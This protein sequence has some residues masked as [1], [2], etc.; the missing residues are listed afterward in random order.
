MTGQ[1]IQTRVLS[2]LGVICVITKNK[3]NNILLKLKPIT[4]QYSI[5]NEDCLFP[6][7]QQSVRIKSQ[8]SVWQYFGHSSF[9]PI[10]TIVF[11]ASAGTLTGI[12]SKLI[13]LHFHIFFTAIYRL[14]IGT[15][16]QITD[17]SEGKL[18]FSIETR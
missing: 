16:A 13:K 6:F 1:V 14:N 8:R 12:F 11:S 10:L 17:N 5:L 18:Y 3:G 9:Q 4:M 7:I 2:R 15:V